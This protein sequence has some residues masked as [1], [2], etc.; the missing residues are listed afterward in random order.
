MISQ[1]SVSDPDS[2]I[3]E[4]AL[5]LPIRIRLHI[6]GFDDQKLLFTYP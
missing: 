2:L 1:K 6:Q 3:P 4:L 5:A